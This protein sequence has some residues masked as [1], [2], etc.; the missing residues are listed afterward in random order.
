[1]RWALLL[2]VLTVHATVG[3]AQQ[4]LT[5]AIFVDPGLVVG[6]GETLVLGPGAVLTGPG[7]VTVRG[8]LEA[9]GEPGA[10]VQLAVPVDLL[11]GSATLRHVRVWG[12]DGDAL[13]VKGGRLV[14]EDALVEGNGV[15][16]A[17]DA[18]EGATLDVRNA[19]FRDHATA[20]ATLAGRFDAAL[21]NVTFAGN[22]RHLALQP[23]DGATLDAEEATFLAPTTRAPSLLVV[24]DEG[25]HAT[26]RTRRA[27]FDGGDV[28]VRVEG[29]GARYVSEDDAFLRVRVGLSL[30]GA[31]AAVARARF[32][33]TERDVDATPAARLSLADVRLTP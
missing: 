10:P 8:T 3:A 5:G 20:G 14:L 29:A 19:T 27:T 23:A 6:E 9:R 22:A 21:R 31:E 24:A 18:P 11:N 12:V 25:V 4:P 30:D 15:G 13:T 2:L 17:V 33:T 26:V 32:E 7:R 16:L 1:M 28:A